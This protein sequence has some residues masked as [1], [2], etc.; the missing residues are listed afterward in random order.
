MSCI[1]QRIEKLASIIL[2]AFYQLTNS[3]KI[4]QESLLDDRS[5]LRYFRKQ[6]QAMRIIM[7][8]VKTTLINV[9]MTESCQLDF[10]KQPG[11]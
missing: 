11:L 6:N 3:V 5:I 8:F 4:K 1:S 10:K 2:L 7:G 9:I